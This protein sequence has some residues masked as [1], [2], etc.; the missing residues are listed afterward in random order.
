MRDQKAFSWPERYDDAVDS[1]VGNALRHG[2]TSQ[3]VVEMAIGS[4]RR[5]RQAQSLFR[6]QHQRL[7]IA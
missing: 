1:A 5:L 6:Q 3:T 7:F 2:Q 4:D